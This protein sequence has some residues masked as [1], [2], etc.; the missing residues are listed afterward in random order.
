MTRDQK[1][2]YDRLPRRQKDEINALGSDDEKR[3]YLV[4]VMKKSQR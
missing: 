1:K 4:E 2:A 3:Q